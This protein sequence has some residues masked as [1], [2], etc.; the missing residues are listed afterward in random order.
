MDYYTCGGEIRHASWKNHHL[1]G[2]TV[3][4]QFVNFA[5]DMIRLIVGLILCAAFLVSGY[6]R[7]Q[8]PVTS[9]AIEDVADTVVLQE[10]SVTSI[11][12]PTK[13]FSLPEAST[14]IGR[15]EAERLN[16]M[17]IKSL[18]DVVPN[19][20]IPD[21]G[22]RITSSIYVRGI[23]ARMDQPSVGL[24]VDNVPFLNKD[25]YD[26]DIA[27]IA[28]VEMLRGPQTALYGR[29]TMAGQINISTLSPFRF[30]GW[31]LKAEFSSPVNVKAA[32]SWY[33]K[34]NLRHALS[35]GASFSWSR[36]LFKNEY[37]GKMAD[38]ERSLG[39]RSKYQWRISDG[40]MLQNV[41]SLSVLRQGGYPYENIESGKIAYNDTCFY[42]RTVVNDGLT[43]TWNADK[44]ILSSMSSFQYIDDNM[45][46]DQ[47]FLPEDYFTLTQKKR[48]PGFTQDLVIKSKDT[49]GC[50]A[51]LAGAFGFYKHLHMD[52]P[53]RFLD[54]GISQLIEHYR[55]QGNPNHPIS[56]DT[57]DFLLSSRFIMPTWGLALYHKSDLSLGRFKLSLAMRLD[58]EHVSMDYHSRCNTGYTV[59]DRQA[60]GSFT[61]AG[62][63]VVDI[64]DRGKHSNHFLNFIPKLTILY[65][66]PADSPANLYLNIAKGYKSGGFNTQMFSDVLQQRLMGLM[67]IGAAYDIEKM[68]SYKPEYSWNFE[69]GSHLSFSP[70]SI[71]A[72][73]AAFYIDCRDQQLTMFPPGTTTGRMMTNA[74]KTRSFGFELS[75]AATPVDPLSLRVSYG[76]T[77]AKFRDFFDGKVN[78]AGKYLPYAPGNTLFVQAVY[79]L[80]LSHSVLRSLDFDLNLRGTGKIYWDEENTISQPFYLLPGASVTLMADKWDVKIYG[81]NL[82]D[83]R[84]HTFYFKS[85][86]NRFLQRGKPLQVGVAISAHI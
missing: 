44:F 69:I 60:D 55:N 78:H 21:Y 51:W 77:N 59:F 33:H 64:D 20:F 36:G 3:N 85:I 68:V 70:W 80:A 13:L 72:D 8:V 46:L 9:S 67:G 4:L 28:S 18:S 16:A 31:R 14:V 56:W 26:L 30:Q 86:G 71:T 65:D 2:L 1:L 49:G 40:V 5:F 35:F 23:G 6:A 62:H 52:A 48:E 43:L 73:I 45:T 25:A 50:Y 12:Q 27:D 66:L 19:F 81:T 7:A 75:V 32:A 76:Y 17:A 41:A 61:P 38:P 34:F 37:N 39:L 74:G 11:K 15:V 83:T 58:Y 47:D 63:A 29:N 42:K 84:Y 10:I 22:S 79:S 54:H 53:V 82:S 24:N 57:R